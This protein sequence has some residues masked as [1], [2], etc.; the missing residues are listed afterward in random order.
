MFL[1]SD[2]TVLPTHNLNQ[3]AVDNFETC[4]TFCSGGVLY[5]NPFKEKCV[6]SGFS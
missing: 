6:K 4:I 5:R 3:H 2:V 1:R